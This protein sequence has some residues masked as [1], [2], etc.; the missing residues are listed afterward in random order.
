MNDKDSNG[1]SKNA[2]SK[3]WH[4]Y[5]SGGE[6]L[7][8]IDGFMQSHRKIFYGVDFDFSTKYIIENFHTNIGG[9]EVDWFLA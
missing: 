6:V 4:S 5:G 9:G 8:I 7:N 2:G 1:D 3:Q